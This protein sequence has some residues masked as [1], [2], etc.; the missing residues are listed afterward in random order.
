VV[1]PSDFVEAQH[2]SDRLG[3]RTGLG[4]GGRPEFFFE[5]ATEEDAATVLRRCRLQG[6][7]VRILGGGW[8]LLVEDADLAGAVIATGAIRHFRLHDDRVEVGAGYPFQRLVQESI[9]LGIPA[10]P[11]CPGIPGSVGGVVAMNAGG[12]FGCAGDALVEV[13][14]LDMAGTP[15]RQR[16]REGDLGYRRSCFEGLLVTSAVFRRDPTIDV[17]AQRHLYET[18][19]RWKQTTQPLSARSAGCVFK[20]PDGTTGPRTAGRLIDEAGLKGR[21]VGGAEVSPQHANFIVNRGGATAKDVF[22]LIDLVR[23]EVRDRHDVELELEVKVWR[24]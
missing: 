23:G 11:G 3:R 18:A 19:L 5:P 16:V 7:P 14:G 1:L 21:S 15:F 24:P 9:A 4:V 10:L 8:N 13:A 6:I 12:R 2:R 17:A 22:A 20:N